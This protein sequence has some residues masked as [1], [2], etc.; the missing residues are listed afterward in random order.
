MHSD[1]K[2]SFHDKYIT[3]RQSNKYSSSGDAVSY[4]QHSIFF[5]VAWDC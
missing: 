4:W 1:G 5:E 3:L 2:H